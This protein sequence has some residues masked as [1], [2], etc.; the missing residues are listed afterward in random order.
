MPVREPDGVKAEAFIR[1]QLSTAIVELVEDSPCLMLST[2]GPQCMDRIESRFEEIGIELGRPLEVL[3]G[4]RRLLD[5]ILQP[6]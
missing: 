4:G 2:Q 6:I 5:P 3:E 1:T